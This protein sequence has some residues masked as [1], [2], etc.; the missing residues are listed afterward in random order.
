MKLPLQ[1]TASDL[2]GQAFT[3]DQLEVFEEFV[4][5]ESEFWQ[6][7]AENQLA[8]GYP[9]HSYVSAFNL[10]LTISSTIESWKPNLS[11]WD[12]STF[13]G[14]LSNLQSNYLNNIYTQWIWS[15][16][17]FILPWLDSYKYSATTA[18]GFLE[19]ITKKTTTNVTNRDYLR[20]YTLAYEYELQDESR[21]TKRR[22]AE[23][24]SI[25]SIRNQ[26]V[27]K[28]NELISEVVDFETEIIVWKTNTQK[29]F[30]EWHKNQIK[31]SDDAS[32]YQSNNF[33]SQLSSWIEK[34]GELENIYKEKLRFD[35]PA[36]YWR[37]KAKKFRN[38]GTFWALALVTSIAT[39]ICYFSN[40]FIAWLQGQ[41]TELKLQSLE[42]IVL[43]A[44]ILSTFAFL[45]KSLSRLTFSS[46]H[47]QRDAEE[48]E[49][50][51]HLYLALSNE[52]E[53]DVE[54]RRIVLQALFSRSESGLLANENG[55]TMPGNISD[56]INALKTTK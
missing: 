34:I 52:K 3:F 27:K 14:Q 16:H 25:S 54:S 30:S 5:T 50:L 53:V 38:Q 51:T 10:F 33:H 18:E 6:E 46:F 15:G 9:V 2:T 37:V 49:Q 19:S 28:K 13:S 47:L 41:Q 12:E 44:A 21:I 45:I 29:E 26:L 17:S 39:G 32:I 48:R 7:K 56:I 4:K 11:A 1:L 40:F 31:N 22:L 23:E 36:S 43:F 55:P 24:K 20:G 42:G 35:S 8:L